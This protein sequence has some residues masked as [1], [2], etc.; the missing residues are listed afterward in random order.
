MKKKFKKLLALLL[1]ATMI[2]GLLSGFQASASPATSP[3]SDN[4]FKMAILPDT[5][6]YARYKNELWLS[7]TNWIAKNAKKENIVFTAHLGDLVDRADEEYEW[8]NADEAM[9]VFDKAKLPYGFLAGN[10]DV[11]NSQQYD[12]ERDLAKEPFLNY[13]STDRMKNIPGFTGHSEDGFNSYYVFEGSGKKY[14]ALFLDWRA[15]EETLKWAQKAIDKHPTYPVMV[16]THQLLNISNDKKSAVMTDHGQFLW[17]KLIAKNDQ[18]FL[19]VN[20]HHHGY[21]HTVKKNNKGHDVVMMVVDYQSAFHGGN[22]MLRTL[23]FDMDKNRIHTSSFSPWVMGM[24]EKQR[25]AFDEE[26]LVDDFNDFTVAMDFEER[27][28]GFQPIISVKKEVPKV[29]GTVAYWQMDNRSAAEGQA[30]A[31]KGAAVKD[32]SGKGNDL[33]RIDEGDAKPGDLIWYKGNAQNPQSNSGIRFFNNKS[34]KKGSYLKTS[35]QAPINAQTFPNG[36]TIEAVVKLGPDFDADKHSWMGILGRYGTGQDV[37]KKEGDADAPLATLAVS[38]LREIQW[39]S[40]PLNYGS[41]QT[42][43]SWEMD[44][45]W[46]HIAL[47]NNGQSTKMYIDGVE[48]L[49]NPDTKPQGIATTG[50]PWIIGASQYANK[51]DG[52]F[53]GWISE[54]RIV[55][56]ALNKKDFLQ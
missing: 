51:L 46:H 47:V 44:D 14:M 9:K 15:S 32:L 52:V 36:Y 1:P 23:E 4:S 22:G 5:Q 13:F 7:Q 27:F 20:G 41:E 2:A 43:W 34:Q 40:F 16:F 55:D 31:G 39:A 11:L 50:K 30:V 37:G 3:D 6:K 53:N 56:H 18:I 8:R 33:Y 49:R 35:D 21:A 28:S 12:N 45:S 17:D 42:S 10:H 26:K 25:T 29:E 54:I 19:T 24:P 38:S 48:V